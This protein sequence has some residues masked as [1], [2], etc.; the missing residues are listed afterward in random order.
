LLTRRTF[1]GWL[2]SVGSAIGLGARRAPTTA[3]RDQ[4]SGLDVQGITRLAEAVLPQELGDLGLARVS[5]GFTQWVAG[6]RAGAELV[7]PYGSAEIEFSG[8]SPSRR[9]ITQLDALERAARTAHRRSFAAL[10]VPQR[11]AL[12]ADALA[13]DRSGRLPNPTSARHVAVALL[14]WFYAT[15]EATD[16]C[17]RARID[18]NQCRP[19]GQAS[20]EPLPLRNPDRDAPAPRRDGP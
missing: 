13:D 7:H 20:R 15:P 11:R 17:Y 6:Y 3:D 19:L 4:G 10:T 14:A 1:V 5:R 8:E 12:V 16:L 2:G 9:W 18:A